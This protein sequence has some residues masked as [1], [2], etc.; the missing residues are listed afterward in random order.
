MLFRPDTPKG[1]QGGEGCTVLTFRPMDMLSFTWSAPPEWPEIRKE[2]TV[3]VIQLYDLD[4]SGTRVTL[5]HVGFGEG[6][7]WDEV[8][9]YFTEVRPVVW[10][11]LKDRFVKGAIDWTA[12]QRAGEAQAKN[13]ATK[14]GSK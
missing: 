2:R 1:S 3:V 12:V 14:K 5:P 7:G 9:H 10:G 4:N 11:R 6:Q 13:E 8:H